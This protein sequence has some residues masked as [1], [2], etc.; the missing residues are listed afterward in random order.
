MAYLLLL[1]GFLILLSSGNYLVKSSVAIA[2]RFQISPLVI[3]VTI[4]SFG[5]SA[6]ELLV[7]MQAA[8]Q[9]H[10]DISIGN[11]VGSN[12]SN[13]ALVLAL[14]ALIFPI[15]VKS[16]SV[17]IDWPVMMLASMLFWLF[18]Q[19]LVLE[20]WEGV[21]FLTLLLCYIV[22]IVSRSKRKFSISVDDKQLHSPLPTSIAVFVLS[23]AGLV[24][25]SNLLVDNAVTVARNFNVSERVISVSLIAFGTSVPELSTSVVAAFKKQMDI[26]IGNIIG[27]NI[28]N[29]FV[30]I[31]LTSVIHPIQVN[32]GTLHY[33]IYWMIGFAIL[34]FLFILPLKGGRLTR[35]K[36][37]IMFLGYLLYI[38]M[39]IL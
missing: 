21:L 13:I 32:T 1:L 31:G 27:S 34:L 38:A 29:L 9:G 39:L 19:N 2:R 23:V 6:P 25:G 28:F 37:S 12:I 5:T 17:K 3:G 20:R 30:V 11:V 35:W 24:L 4:V 16:D 18:S 15:P 36:G 7:S 8:L 10:P 14:T 33:D 22:Y 26:S